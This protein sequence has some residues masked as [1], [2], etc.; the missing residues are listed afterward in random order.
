MRVYF[1]ESK[2]GAVPCW[3]ENGIMRAIAAESYWFFATGIVRP[4]FVGAAVDACSCQLI[5]WFTGQ[6]LLCLRQWQN[7]KVVSWRML[8]SNLIVRQGIIFVEL[9]EC[10][11]A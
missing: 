5:S 2:I 4:S 8:T 7:R 1:K 10:V 6:L 9:L 3:E 11:E